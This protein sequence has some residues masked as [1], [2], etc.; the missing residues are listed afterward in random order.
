MSCSTL[1]TRGASPK[2]L[3]R[4]LASDRHAWAGTLD[5]EF[6]H[7]W[8]A[9]VHGRQRTHR[10]PADASSGP[11]RVVPAGARICGARDKDPPGSA[12]RDS[13]LQAYAAVHDTRERRM[14]VGSLELMKSEF[15]ACA[16]AS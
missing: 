12:S 8:G 7:G 4:P 11:G 16:G 1:V 5:E 9:S 15:V 14:D 6:A 10:P 3:A 2:L 13:A